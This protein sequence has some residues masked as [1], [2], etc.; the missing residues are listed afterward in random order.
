MYICLAPAY[1]FD[2]TF[3]SLTFNSFA[4]LLLALVLATG[5][6]VGGFRFRFA[7]HSSSLSSSDSSLSVDSS[8]SSSFT[9]LSLAPSTESFLFLLCPL[10]LCSASLSSDAFRAAWSIRGGSEARSLTLRVD[11]C[12]DIAAMQVGE[13]G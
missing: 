8:P 12:C 10:L 6:F 2:I 1:R 7:G 4:L 3:N 9:R 13:G 5:A 11:F